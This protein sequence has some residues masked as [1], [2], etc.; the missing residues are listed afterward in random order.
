MSQVKLMP[1]DR[2]RHELSLLLKESKL[3][4][5][6]AAIATLDNLTDNFYNKRNSS[7][8]VESASMEEEKESLVN[9][10]SKDQASEA[11]V[12]GTPVTMKENEST[13]NKLPKPLGFS[14][15][16]IEHFIYLLIRHGVDKASKFNDS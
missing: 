1:H 11:M 14:L 6:E 2:V 13:S 5:E 8:K 3:V 16:V 4:N 10:D 9:S 12:L 7:T 15:Q